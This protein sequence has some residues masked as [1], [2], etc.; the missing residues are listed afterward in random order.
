MAPLWE[1]TEHPQRECHILES[2][3]LFYTPGLLGCCCLLL[4][5]LL[6]I[7]MTLYLL[8]L[9]H[10]CG[11]YDIASAAFR[12]FVRRFE[13]HGFGRPLIARTHLQQ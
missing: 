1:T 10:V 9:L 7:C 13:W 8:L 2:K 3:Y 4:L 6:M 12:S 11:M 5:L